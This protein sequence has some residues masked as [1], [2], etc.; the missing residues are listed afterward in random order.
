[1]TPEDLAALQERAYRDMS[2]W[3]GRDF[4]DLLAQ[5]STLLIADPHAFCMGRV[6]VDEAEILAFATDPAHQRQG[7]G[8]RLLDAFVQAAADRGAATIFLEVAA[9][10]DAALAFYSSHGFVRTGLRKG[11]YRQPDDSRTD[12]LLMSRA[13]TRGQAPDS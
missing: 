7:L 10:N 8:A 5:S 12:A 9:S 11:Y 4:A 3:S 6:I 2:P 13:L 1:M